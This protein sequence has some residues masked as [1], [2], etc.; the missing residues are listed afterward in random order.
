M[1]YS[2]ARHNKIETVDRDAFSKMK[3]AFFIYL[4]YN[5]ITTIEANTFRGMGTLEEV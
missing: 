1:F 2:S 4:D 5:L 3:R